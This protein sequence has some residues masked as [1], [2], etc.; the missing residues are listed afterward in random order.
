MKV[1]KSF[2]VSKVKVTP[3]KWIEVRFGKIKSSNKIWRK[4]CRSWKEGGRP[5]EMVCKSGKLRWVSISFKSL[6]IA[7]LI[8][9]FI[10]P[11]SII[12]VKSREI[13]PLLNFYRY[14]L[15]NSF[16][17][18]SLIVNLLN[19]RYFIFSYSSLWFIT[20]YYS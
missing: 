4:L 9:K 7:H 10:F 8:Y 1:F 3:Y 6:R 19:M 18:K 17:F 15:I 16:V 20:L 5:R 12:P 11:R 2:F 13:S 14:S